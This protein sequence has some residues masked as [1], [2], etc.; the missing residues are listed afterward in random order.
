MAPIWPSERYK[1]TLNETFHGCAGSD[2][3][4]VLIWVASAAEAGEFGDETGGDDMASLRSWLDEV[5]DGMPWEIA[6]PAPPDGSTLGLG[7][8]EICT[9]LSAV[10]ALPAF[11]GAIRNWHT[12]RQDP[13][14]ITLTITIDPKKGDLTVAFPDGTEIRHADQSHA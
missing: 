5:A 9:V 4:Q 12:T 10:E 14:P 1:L 13:A 3:V 8:E 6:P 2:G 7:A 11:I